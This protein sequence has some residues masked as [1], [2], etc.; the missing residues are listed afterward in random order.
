MSP[1]VVIAKRI[2]DSLNCV[3]SKESLVMF[4]DILVQEKYK[5]G[6]RILDEGDVCKSL[7]FVD[8][9]M[10]RQFYYKYGKDLTEHIAYEDSIVV[11]L[12]SYFFEKPTS[13]MIETLEAT[14]LW[15]IDKTE[16]LK[17]VDINKE[18]GTLYRSVF[19][20]SLITSQR[21]ADVIRFEPAQE[22]YNKLMQAHPEVLKRAPLIYIA[23]LLQMTPETLSRVRSAVLNS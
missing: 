5:K 13:L 1:N 2:A 14:V 12:E 6:E 10:T 9:G 3:L 8:K 11:C 17:L 7:Y 19:E 16:I 18:I 23:S 22:R 4:A 15:R 21:K 20:Y